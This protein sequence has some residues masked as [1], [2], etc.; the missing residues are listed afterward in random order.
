M[1]K[2]LDNFLSIIYYLF[3]A[4]ESTH[5]ILFS[6]LLNTVSYCY[7]VQCNKTLADSLDKCVDSG[8][9]TVNFLL[10]NIA[11]SAM[12]QAQYFSTGS[13]KQERW[14]H[15]GLALGQY[16]HFTSPIRR[17]ADILVHR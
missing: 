4:A 9:W 6:F 10:R 3:S 14:S 12:E 11:T 1:R 16:T 5:Y 13:V 15:Y 17:Y 2:C 7:V 8:D